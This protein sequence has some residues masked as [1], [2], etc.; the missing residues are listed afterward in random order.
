MVYNGNEI[1]FILLMWRVE[2]KELLW[3]K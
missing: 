3:L 1:V 2:V